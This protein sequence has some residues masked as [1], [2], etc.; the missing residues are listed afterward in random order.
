[1]DTEKFQDL[2]GES[3]SWSRTMIDGLR[4]D[5]LGGSIVNADN[6]GEFFLV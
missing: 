3:L 2:Q 6:F 4:T 1:M 5:I